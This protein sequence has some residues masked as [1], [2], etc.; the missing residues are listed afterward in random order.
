[1]A[2]PVRIGDLAHRLIRLAGMVPGRDIKVEVTGRRE[3][4][5]MTEQLSLEPLLPTSNPKINVARTG[6]SLG[7]A[8]GD[9]VPQLA[10]LAGDGD[11]AGIRALL[12]EVVGASWSQD[13]IQGGVPEEGEEEWT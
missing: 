11:M 2:D 3:G 12:G 4:E 8:I 9:A 1:M 10:K 5:K 7:G 13:V 6:A